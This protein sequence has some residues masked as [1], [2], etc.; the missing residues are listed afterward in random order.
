MIKALIVQILW[1]QHERIMDKLAQ[2]RAE[3]A[4]LQS[5]ERMLFKDLLAVRVAV[6]TQSRNISEL[7]NAQP[8][9]INRLPVELLLKTFSFLLAR[10]DED[11][12][13]FFHCLPMWRNDLAGVSRLWKDLVLDTPSFW[14]DIGLIYE[15]NSN[16]LMT[17]LK[18]SREYPLDITILDP[19]DLDVLL[20]ILI[21]STNCWRSLHVGCPKPR[22]LDTIR[23]KFCR[24]EFPCLEDVSVEDHQRRRVIRQV[25]VFKHL[26]TLSPTL[27]TLRLSIKGEGDI[28]DQSFFKR[29]P[30]QS[31]TMLTFTCRDRW[32]L[33]PNSL[34]FP[35]L[36]RLVM[37]TVNLH[38]FMNAIVTPKLQ[39]FDYC[40][41]RGSIIG[42]FGLKFSHVPYLTLNSTDKDDFSGMEDPS[43][44]HM[45]CEAFPGTPCSSLSPSDDLGSQ[46]PVDSWESLEQLSLIV[47]CNDR[48]WKVDTL[49]E[50][51]TKRQKLGPPSP[52]VQ[53]RVGNHAD[54]VVLNNWQG[55]SLENM[56]VSW[57]PNGHIM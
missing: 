55:V 20:N 48:Y 36:E 54:M 7:V 14:C 57:P 41:P 49:A 6:E 18:R 28:H 32:V 53:L 13:I 8:S 38:D 50:W 40:H 3:L 51:L 30:T 25:D 39:H 43:E 46:T 23:Y 47:H 26:A 2:A 37:D 56:D 31:L 45:L 16:L 11:P 44:A 12:Y 22:D 27:T 52:H 9:Q 35:L 10:G 1:L 34:H 33:K 19:C 15:S 5:T 29:I 17:Q 21:P 24:L 4:R 42:P